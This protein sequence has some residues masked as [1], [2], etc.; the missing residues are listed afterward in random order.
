MDAKPAKAW[1]L[2]LDADGVQ[3]IAR[4]PVIVQQGRPAAT[5]GFVLSMPL[6]DTTVTDMRLVALSAP[7]GQDVEQAIADI[8]GTLVSHIMQEGHCEM[9]AAVPFSVA[10]V[11]VESLTRLSDNPM[12][13]RGYVGGYWT[14]IALS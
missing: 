6:M 13:I 11:A 9:L 1:W 10:D 12:V 3:V 5:D 8:G 4:L 2:D 14:P 7:S